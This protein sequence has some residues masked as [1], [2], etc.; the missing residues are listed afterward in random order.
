MLQ[1]VSMPGRKIICLIRFSYLDAA[2]GSYVQTRNRS[3]EE[4]AELLFEDDRMKRRF[5]LFES[6]CLP[7]LEAQ[8]SELF[9]CILLCSD[10][11][12]K[13]WRDRIEMRLA[14]SRN[15]VPVFREPGIYSEMFS[16]AV[17][18]HFPD[19]DLAMTMRL[20]DDDALA[21]DFS[22]R[23]ADLIT[24]NHAGY[25]VSLAN[26]A[27]ITGRDDRI[28]CWEKFWFC[29]SAGLGYI[30]DRPGRMNVYHCGSH[31][32]VSSMYPTITMTGAPAYLQTL[33]GHNDSVRKVREEAR[34]LGD[35]LAR[36]EETFG[37]LS[38]EKIHTA[39]N[40]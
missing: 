35:F 27:E 37:F 38:L 17:S 26:G 6:V 11:M 12:P 33:H 39:M 3:V 14:D 30:S 5:A 24:V 20:D 19:T 15:V 40:G 10:R 31:A 4:R 1:K 34:S 13:P 23:V 21:G 9:S 2:G 28:I 36:H 29:G 16:D 32:R 8:P 18:R 7:S 25:C 22:D